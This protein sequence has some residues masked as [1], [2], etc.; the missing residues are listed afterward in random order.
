MNAIRVGPCSGCG[1]ESLD[2]KEETR[3]GATVMILK[4]PS[5][6]RCQNVGRV[7]HALYRAQYRNALTSP[8][9]LCFIIFGLD[10]LA[11]LVAFGRVLG[12]LPAHLDPGDKIGD[13]SSEE[14]LHALIARERR[15]AEGAD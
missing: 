10:G 8:A 1:A 3:D 15:A 2:L 4:C 13:Y 5:C 6:G 14:E 7:S 9:L 12:A 11:A